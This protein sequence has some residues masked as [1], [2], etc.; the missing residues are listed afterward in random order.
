MPRQNKYMRGGDGNLETLNNIHGRAKQIHSDI[1]T[2]L[3]EA[4]RHSITS[5][6]VNDFNNGINNLAQ[7]ADELH[8]NVIKVGSPK[9]TEHSTNMVNHAR[10]SIAHTNQ[11]NY[12]DAVNSATDVTKHM[13]EAIKHATDDAVGQIQLSE[14]N[15]GDHLRSLRKKGSSL[16]M[17]GGSTRKKKSKDSNY[18]RRKHKIISS[19]YKYSN[20]YNRLPKSSRKKRKKTK[21]K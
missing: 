4:S 20:Y 3:P 14:A 17:G 1:K 6:A 9:A 11:G 15:I 13:S 18:G 2:S 10:D 12:Q 16:F 7:H 19:S 5:S 8:Q 21:K